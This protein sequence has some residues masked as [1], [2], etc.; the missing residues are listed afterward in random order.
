MATAEPPSRGGDQQEG[1]L[2]VDRGGG[3]YSHYWKS[4]CDRMMRSDPTL[5]GLDIDGASDS[6]DEVVVESLMDSLRVAR[7]VTHLKLVN[8]EFGPQLSKL[9]LP[10]IKRS[11]SLEAIHIEDCDDPH[12]DMADALAVAFLCKSCRVRTLHVRGCQLDPTSQSFGLVLSACLLTELRISH[13]V[14]AIDAPMARALARGLASTANSLRVL[15]LSG[16]GM[17]DEAVREL[18]KGLLT[19]G[20][21]SALEFLSLDF[22]AFGDDGVEALSLALASS[23]TKLLELHLFGNQVSHV[24]AAHLAGALRVN[25]TLKSLILSF[26]RIGGCC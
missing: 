22:N 6:L 13:N 1:E 10:G 2:G 24:G 3:Y 25:V 14:S 11:R 26:N 9:L 8:L 23:Q 17:D 15:D 16:N 20:A 12:G 19:L 21:N 18:S 4:L 5:T 7:S